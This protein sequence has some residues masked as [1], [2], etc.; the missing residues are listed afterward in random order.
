MFVYSEY[1]FHLATWRVHFRLETAFDTASPIIHINT[2]D[3]GA[4]FLS[5]LVFTPLHTYISFSKRCFFTHSHWKQQNEI[6][7]LETVL[8]EVSISF[9]VFDRFSVEYAFP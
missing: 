6:S 7:T 3:N 4:E 2:F 9:V 1:D 8:L 5:V